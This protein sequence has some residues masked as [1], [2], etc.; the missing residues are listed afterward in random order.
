MTA[1]TDRVEE[2]RL[3]DNHI[4]RLRIQLRDKSAEAMKI[5]VSLLVDEML[6]KGE[7][8][9][10]AGNLNDIVSYYFGSMKLVLLSDKST[11]FGQLL[12]RIPDGRNSIEPFASCFNEE[13]KRRGASVGIDSIYG[14]WYGTSVVSA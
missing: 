4:D 12:N 6:E 2:L 7:E 5:Y 11:Y 14:G 3:L 10:Y 1:I 8:L 9:G 13:L